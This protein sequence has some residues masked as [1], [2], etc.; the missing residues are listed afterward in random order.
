MTELTSG[1]RDPLSPVDEDDLLSEEADADSGE[2][3]DN[4]SKNENNQ[5]H[6]DVLRAITQLGGSIRSMDKSRK[7]LAGTQADTA[8]PPKRSKTSST[9]PEINNSDDSDSEKSDSEELNLSAA[10]G[11]TPSAG[12][13]DKED[14]LLN[15]IAQNF[16]SD[17][18]TDP[19]VT[20][21]L[22]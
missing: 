10:K 11:D 12:S 19:K 18:K 22:A 17:E 9:A 21:N 1:E 3:D 2:K 16:E 5:L 7:R 4:S 20:Q 15:E 13:A 8:T 6:T 14:E